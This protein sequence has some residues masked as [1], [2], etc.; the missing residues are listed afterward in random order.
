MAGLCPWWLLEAYKIKN[1]VENPMLNLPIF[2]SRRN[3]TQIIIL[4]SVGKIVYA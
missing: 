3:L 2:F 4:R 1:C